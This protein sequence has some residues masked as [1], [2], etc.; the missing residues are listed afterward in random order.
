MNKRTK[1]ILLFT[2]I[3]F[4]LL[5]LFC[6]LLYSFYSNH[7]LFAAGSKTGQAQLNNLGLLL[8]A[9]LVTITAAAFIS[10]YFFS[11]T[12]LGPVK[13]I[14]G[15][16]STISLQSITHRLTPANESGEWNELVQTINELLNRLQESLEI[17]RRFLAAASHEL[18]TP[19]TAVSSQLEVALL[20]ERDA[21]AYRQVMQSVYQ[22][23]QQLSKLTQTL[24]EFASLSG[25]PGGIELSPVR[26]DEVLLQLPGEM[27]KMNKGYTVK[28][29]FDRLPEDAS[30]LLVFGN[31]ALL[32]T[33]VK[34]IVTNACKYAANRQAVIKLSVVKDE[35]IIAVKDDGKGI[36]EQ[37]IKNIFQPFYR[38][39]DGSG[40]AGF[41]VGLTLVN[42]IIKLHNGRIDVKSAPGKGTT[43][44]V[45][46]HCAAKPL[47]NR[48]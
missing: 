6:R 35:I 24:L 47:F 13:R 1:I 17:Q 10:A 8:I 29:E 16:V 4:L 22:D 33:A 9:G 38:V 15:E 14:A 18:L 41:G 12:L 19:L 40:V 37:E 34:N 36:P 2:G 7:M 46:L 30:R 32:F 42:R 23:V 21:T 20:K 39:D 44:F 26:I 27:A 28:F 31:A 25:N 3:L 45:S 11:K 5:C 43:F 48:L